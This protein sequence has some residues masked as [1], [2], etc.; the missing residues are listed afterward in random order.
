MKTVTPKQMKDIDKYVIEE[1]GIPGILLME[2]AALSV[3]SEIEKTFLSLKK[4]KII[5][6]AGKGNNG[7]DALAIG[8]L[9][10]NRDADIFIYI[11][12]KKQ[13]LKGDCAKNLEILEN[14]GIEIVELLYQD[15][16]QNLKILLLSADMIVDGIFGTGIRGEI[17]GLISEIIEIINH[18]GK[19]ILSIDIPSGIDGLTGRIL[20]N[21]IKANK[22]VTFCLPK[23]GLLINPGCQN[24]GELIVSEISIPQKVIKEFDIK[25]NLIDS[26][27]V[28]GLMPKRNID[29]NKGDF[30]R[31]FI[32]S[33]SVGMT[34][35]GCL[36]ASAALRCG[37]GLVYLGVPS[38]LTSIYETSLMEAVTIPLCDND[39]GVLS[40]QSLKLI[41]D[42][43]SKMS[44]VAIGPGLSTSGDIFEIVASLIKEL[45]LPL[46]LDADALNV[47]IGRTDLL[48]THTQ[49]II[50]TPHP[51]E[52]SRLLGI[53]IEDVQNNRIEVAGEFAQK[54]GVI[55]V[56]KG[57]RTIIA[58]PAGN[59]YINPTGNSGMATAGMGD[60]LTGIIASLIA[61]GL[62]PI[63]G[64]VC[65]VFLHGLAGDDIA[66]NKGEH[67][68]IASDLVSELPLTIKKLII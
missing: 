43:C 64:A 63:D 5:I 52:I 58:D 16:L 36:S 48:K 32:I 40:G 65:G 10:F 39:K 27:I 24:T 41:M 34:G 21:T 1:I 55:T 7:G 60:V 2:N 11:T 68:M 30:G 12:S 47:L 19:Y 18:S 33:G 22:T 50:V 25:I 66:R 35:A 9:F 26:E 23:L 4:K 17:K 38:I 46:I 62:K 13:E 53:S 42:S 28:S 49:E 59:I 54:F 14:M 37:A 57:S 3:V 15:Q 29:N 44:V 56:L 6:F 20:G 67:G 31:V 45:K 8:R 61:Q 51:G